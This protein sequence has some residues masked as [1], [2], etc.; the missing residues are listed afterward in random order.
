[1]GTDPAP[2]FRRILSPARQMERF[3]PR[4]DYVRR[5]VPE[6][7]AVPDEHL[8]EPWAMPLPIQ[9]AAGCLIGKDYPGPIVDHA[10]ARQE[11]LERYRAG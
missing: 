11:A 3:D 1:V 7:R 10:R 6:L 2:A 8:R 9:R 4:G 5:Y